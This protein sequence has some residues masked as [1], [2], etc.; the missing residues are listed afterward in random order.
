[1]QAILCG[2]AALENLRR[3][4][5][6]LG[7]A[8]SRA[9][10]LPERKGPV[11]VDTPSAT[12]VS[13]LVSWGLVSSPSD[14]H[15]LV[16][17]N[18]QRRQ[19]KGVTYTTCSGPFPAGSFE[20]LAGQVYTVSAELLF[21]LAARTLPLVRL[22]ELGY[23]LCGTYRLTEGVPAYG[24]IPLTNVAHLRAYL[25]RATGI[26]G[27]KKAL[28]A[29]Q[30]LVDGS[31]SPAETA[32]AIVFVLPYRHGGYGLG[33]FQLNRSITLNETAARMLG[34]STI[35]PDF[36]WPKARYPVEYDSSLYHSG[37]EQA[38]YD[39]RRRNAY[40]A[41]KMGITVLRPRHILNFGLMDEA[42]Q[43]IRKN[44]GKKPGRA[45]TDYTYLKEEL[46][47][48]AFRYWLGLR[49]D[50]GTGDEFALRASSWAE[51]DC[52]WV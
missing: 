7:G 39:E 35:R 23:E 47:Q 21:L 2:V 19:L 50:F 9:P 20:R 44:I 17:A 43:V 28:R 15:L 36:Y 32:L 11:H 46:R 38:D 14:V 31:A 52:P 34:R 33:G 48:E 8:D 37:R 12:T 16:T 45:P 13:D 49:D 6:L 40:S 27:R 25:N 26:H 41:M 4:S 10:K 24:R 18:T 5:P 3:N 42:A 29:T 30:W 1:M 22:L 51:P